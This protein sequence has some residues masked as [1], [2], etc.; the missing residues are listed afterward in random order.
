MNYFFTLF[1]LVGLLL[2]GISEA[3]DSAKE[4]LKK[5]ELLITG[6]ARSGTTYVACV[7]QKCGLDVGNISAI[8]PMGLSLGL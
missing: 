7:L 6:C 8:N 5:R 1:C 2:S 3:K 4:P